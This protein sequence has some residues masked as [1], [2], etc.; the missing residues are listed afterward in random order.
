[1]K[2]SKSSLKNNYITVPLQNH[3][4]LILSSLLTLLTPKKI[5]QFRFAQ[6]DN[7]V[8]PTVT[9]WSGGIYTKLNKN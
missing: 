9:K 5:F 3:V 8:I 7:F 6:H 1:M 2:H 4:C